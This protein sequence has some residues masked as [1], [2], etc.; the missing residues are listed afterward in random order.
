MSDR[1][2]IL[3]S[4]LDLHLD[5]AMATIMEM[6]KEATKLQSLPGVSTSSLGNG[7]LSEDQ[8][9]KLLMRRQNSV[10]KRHSK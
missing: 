9:A 3:K 10:Q 8:I 5:A 4:Q 1:L 2:K 7:A 6:R